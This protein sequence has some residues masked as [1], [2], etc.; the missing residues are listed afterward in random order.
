MKKTL[1]FLLA[2]VSLALVVSLAVYLFTRG[3][4]SKIKGPSPAEGTASKG[5]KEG[6][7]EVEKEEVTLF[8]PTMEGYLKRQLREIEK[9]DS[10][11]QKAMEILSQLKDP[12][13]G[14]LSPFPPGGEARRVFIIDGEA[15]V[16]VVLPGQGFGSQYELLTVYSLVNSLTYNLEAVEK[17]KIVV[18]GMERKTLFGHLSLKYPFFQDLSY[19]E[20]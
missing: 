11:E 19:A 1:I 6:V 12:P 15:V 3:E 17:V 9:K 7:A 10:P 16:D 5:E 18:G 20:E 4:S 14:A 2:I 13:S 8:F